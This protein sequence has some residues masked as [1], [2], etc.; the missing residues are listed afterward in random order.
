MFRLTLY[1]NRRH[2]VNRLNS[3]KLIDFLG[4]PGIGFSKRTIIILGVF[5]FKSAS[6]KTSRS[7]KVQ[8][9][10][11]LKHKSNHRERIPLISVRTAQ[12][13]AVSPPHAV[14]RDRRNRYRRSRISGTVSSRDAARPK[15]NSART[16]CVRNF[17]FLPVSIRFRHRY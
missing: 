10:T 8:A 16:A 12:R 11:V 9:R 4:F 14:V 7:P 1:S 2:S 15:R 5:F 13:I 6:R 3:H 17:F